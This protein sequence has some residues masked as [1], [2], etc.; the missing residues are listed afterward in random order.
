M[1]LRN[2]TRTEGRRSSSMRKA[3]S[4]DTICEHPVASAESEGQSCF[5]MA[6]QST[7]ENLWV[8]AKASM[9]YNDKK[10]E[11]KGATGSRMAA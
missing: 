8:L 3:T 9:A 5:T 6:T 4:Q 7:R 2:F 11:T 1:E 10:K